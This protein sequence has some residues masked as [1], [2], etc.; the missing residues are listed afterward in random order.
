M[1]AMQM[2]ILIAAYQEWIRNN[3][4]DVVAESCSIPN[5]QPTKYQFALILINFTFVSL[6]QTR[7]TKYSYPKILGLFV[8]YRQCIDMTHS[9]GVCRW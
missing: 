3:G 1:M 9:F 8:L 5:H 2:H 6:K 7:K 4:S